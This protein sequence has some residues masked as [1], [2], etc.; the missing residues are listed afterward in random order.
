MP[1]G[2]RGDAQSDRALL[3][4]TQRAGS[5]PGDLLQGQAE[6]LGVG[7]FSVE[8]AQCR[9]QGR[10]LLVG[11]GDRRQVE[12]LGAKRVV[13]LLGSSIGGTL[14]GQLNPQ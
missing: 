14:D 6:R 13:L 3:G 10:Q 9:L 8:Q 2:R 1:A 12:V 7:E 4:R 5:P 11:E